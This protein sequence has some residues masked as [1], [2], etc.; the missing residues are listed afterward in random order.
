MMCSLKNLCGRPSVI[1]ISDH[2][3]VKKQIFASY[4]EYS[5]W[6]D[7]LQSEASSLLQDYCLPEGIIPW[8]FL[9]FIGIEMLKWAEYLK[10][11]FNLPV[12]FSQDFIKSSYFTSRGLLDE[13]KAARELVNEP[14]LSVL[15]QYKISCYYFFP[16]IARRLWRQIHN[17]SE[18]KIFFIKESSENP[19]TLWTKYFEETENSSISESQLQKTSRI[20]SAK[21]FSFGMLHGNL[22]A[23][24]FIT[25]TGPRVS[26][27]EEIEESVGSEA[28]FSGMYRI[29]H[30]FKFFRSQGLISRDFSVRR[31][32]T[33]HFVNVAIT[34]KRECVLRR[35]DLVYG[36]LRGFL[37]WPYQDLF[38]KTAKSFF[39]ILSEWHFY[40]LMHHIVQ[41]I[42]DLELSQTY[43]YNYRILLREFWIESTSSHK[44]FFLN[45]ESGFRNHDLS[46]FNYVFAY[47]RSFL[48][49]KI[50]MLNNF[51]YDDETNFRLII[52]SATLKQK[53]NILITQTYK[54]V[55]ELILKKKFKLV[56]M[57]LNTLS[58]NNCIQMEI[59]E[60]YAA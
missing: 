51:S 37:I 44:N 21:V 26:T 17:E 53:K 13:E 5:D 40:L 30:F 19:M 56:D 38:L 60:L 25:M 10:V 8:D 43:K 1:K 57:C 6:S 32:I 52:E 12:K 47:S 7:K 34:Q 46:F 50:I 2:P 29:S 42:S 33:M 35:F 41:A 9:P 18:F 48:L 36:L 4:S 15:L 3:H 49:Q 11:Q 16:D 58:P 20:F 28:F 27:L 54:C 39:Y 23:I 45:I 24:K 59:A 55:S 22:A 14:S 31:D